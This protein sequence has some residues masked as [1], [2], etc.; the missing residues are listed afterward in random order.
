[1]KISA[2]SPKETWSFQRGL[3]SSVVN[4]EKTSFFDNVER[5][6]GVMKSLEAGV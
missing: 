4:S 3:S 6:S 1:M 5:V 2:Q